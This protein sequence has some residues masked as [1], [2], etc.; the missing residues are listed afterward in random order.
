VNIK[1]I[2]KGRTADMKLQHRDIVVVP[3]RFFSF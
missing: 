1:E 2:K 3:E